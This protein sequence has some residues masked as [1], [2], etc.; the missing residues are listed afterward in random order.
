MVTCRIAIKPQLSRYAS[1]LKCM[2]YDSERVDITY[3]H[4]TISSQYGMHVYELSIQDTSAEQHLIQLPLRSSYVRPDFSDARVSTYMDLVMLS[5]DLCTA[6]NV[7]GPHV[8]TVTTD[9]MASMVQSE[10]TTDTGP[11]ATVHH[12]HQ[13]FSQSVSDDD[14]FNLIGYKEYNQELDY[15]MSMSSH[16]LH[17]Q[18]ALPSQNVR[19]YCAKALLSHMPS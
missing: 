2:N 14:A 16:K 12:V 8:P 6:R 11:E 15:Y 3:L 13:D 18:L 1:L 9:T 19:S 17:T 7:Q 10:L 5:H 4:Q